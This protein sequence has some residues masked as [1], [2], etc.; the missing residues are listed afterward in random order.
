M[1]IGTTWIAFRASDCLQNLPNVEGVHVEFTA[2]GES[3]PTDSPSELSIKVLL[4]PAPHGRGHV[5]NKQ[6]AASIAHVW[7][8]D[9]CTLAAKEVTRLCYKLGDEDEWQVG[10]AWLLLLITSALP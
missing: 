3:D 5:G 8:A 2:S 6:L 7:R 4:R 9:A 10:L 1:S